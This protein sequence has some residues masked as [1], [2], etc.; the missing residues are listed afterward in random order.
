MHTNLLIYLFYEEDIIYSQLDLFLIQI[1]M[2]TARY[3]F[4]TICFLQLRNNNIAVL[5]QN[6]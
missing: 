2:S 3:L 1:H 5:L 4:I 6:G